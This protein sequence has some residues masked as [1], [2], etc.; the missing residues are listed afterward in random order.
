MVALNVRKKSPAFLMLMVKIFSPVL[1]LEISDCQIPV[2]CDSW[3]ITLL[4]LKVCKFTWR[5]FNFSIQN[6]CHM[7]S[8]FHYGNNFSIL[9]MLTELKILLN[10]LRIG[11]FDAAQ[12]CVEQKGSLP[13]I[14]HTY[15]T[16]M[17][18]GT[19]IPYL[20]KT[21]KRYESRD[22]PLDLCWNQLFYCKVANF[23]I[24][25]KIA[26]WCIFETLKVFLIKM[27]TILIMSQKLATPGL[28]KI[29]IF[30]NKGYDVI[31]PDSDVT[32]KIL[33][34]DSK[35]IIDAVMWPKF[36]NSSISMREV[37]MTSI[38]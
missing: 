6:I 32:N 17:K 1:T 33:S 27:V 18:L 10:L 9:R 34:R 37:I 26:F 30:R 7:L 28:L 22:T 15:L 2:G 36:G 16:V 20:K 29:K 25:E 3:H 23:A 11:I 21:Q 19:V 35:Y 5:P 14:C 31:I 4:Y 12:G 38:L 8:Y 24:S 13:K